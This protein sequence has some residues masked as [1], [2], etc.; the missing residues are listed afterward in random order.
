MN[1][2]QL[3]RDKANHFVYGALI[4]AVGALA[5]SPEV[6]AIACAVFA[7]GKEVL[8]R[9]RK[10]GTPELADALATVAG[11]AAVLLPALAPRLVGVA[12]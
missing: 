5:H 7:V 10:T 12:S 8:D 2:P 4:A 1:L 9:V 6:G 11:G 3:D